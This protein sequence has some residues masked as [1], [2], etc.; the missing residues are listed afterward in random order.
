[1]CFF[2][3]V[4]DADS[5]EARHC[6]H[7]SN[8]DAYPLALKRAAPSLAPQGSVAYYCYGFKQVSVN[9]HIV[10][11][12]LTVQRFDVNDICKISRICNRY[13]FADFNPCHFLTILLNYNN[14]SLFLII[15]STKLPPG[16][17]LKTIPSLKVL[18]L[19][20]SA[21]IQFVVS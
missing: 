18:P 10:D 16:K 3:L 6:E 19:L 5:F 12:K 9:K 15:K 13:W 21:L 17:S 2:I 20:F 8:A 4:V 14:L 1:M 11:K 7:K